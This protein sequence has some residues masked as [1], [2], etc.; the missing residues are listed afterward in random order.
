MVF[1]I[2]DI[3]IDNQ[4]PY[5]FDFCF[6]SQIRVFSQQLDLF[7]KLCVEFSRIYFVLIPLGIEL[8]N[9]V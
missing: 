4:A 6:D 1:V 8:K 7:I 3:L 5:K 2:D 9:G